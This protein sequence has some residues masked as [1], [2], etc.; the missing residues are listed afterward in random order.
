MRRSY[1]DLRTNE[2]RLTYRMWMRPVAFA[3]GSLAL[4]MFGVATMRSRAR[5]LCSPPRN[6]TQVSSEG[7]T[8]GTSRFFVIVTGSRRNDGNLC[9]LMSCLP[10]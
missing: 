4:L 2:D 5:R 10:N 9:S 8:L 6:V 7:V 1:Q 3:Y